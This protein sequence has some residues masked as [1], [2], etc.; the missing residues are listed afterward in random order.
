MF[1]FYHYRE[2]IDSTKED[3]SSFDC[4][5]VCDSKIKPCLLDNIKS[6]EEKG[7][8]VL[9][10]CDEQDCIIYQREEFKNHL[11]E[12]I[13]KNVAKEILLK[14][15]KILKERITDFDDWNTAMSDLQDLS[16]QYEVEM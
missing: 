15:K 5:L 12:D 1:K 13:K 8:K 9:M 4:T 3:E 2:N 6:F 11:A 16:K 10:V 14:V 7:L